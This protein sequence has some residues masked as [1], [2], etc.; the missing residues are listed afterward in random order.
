ME[1]QLYQNVH[2]YLQD[3]II[4][5]QINDQRNLKKWKN[6]CKPYHLVNQ[7]LYRKTKWSPLT[8]VIKRGETASLIFLYHNDPLAGHLGTTKVMQKMKLQYF[9]PQMYEEI[10]EYIQS[11]HQCQ[12]HART[13]KQN[14]LYP[15][16]ISAPWERVGIDF[17]GPFPE[18][19]KGNKYI[20]TAMDYFTRWPEARAVPTATSQEAA[21]FIY[22]ELICRHGIINI[23]HSDQGTHFVNEVIADLVQR[24]DMKH[25]KITAYHP[26]ANG[27]VERF[28]G[29]LK[30]TLAKLSDE[31]DQWDDLIYPSLFAYRASPID[32]IGVPPA[33]LEYGRALRY[34]L[35]QL[36]G[37][38]LWQRV[39]QLIDKFPLD[40][41]QIRERLLHK[42]NLMKQG[43][44]IQNSYQFKLGEQVLLK[45]E[46]FTPWKKG[47]EPKWEGPFEIAEVLSH[48]TYRLRDYRG[49]QA[50]PINGDRLKSY[51]DRT[52][53]EP[54][55][56]IETEL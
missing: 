48:G 46:T 50:K 22:E 55:V 52:Y 42:Q 23:L 19:T 26:Q 13:G 25:H 29:T 44:A 34:P 12:I 14:E 43:Y 16:P 47:L 11:C 27:L 5:P 56:V 17:V 30:K 9:W 6:F 39:K 41:Q 31:S 32:S 49:I 20:I 1:H 36:P 2:Q 7:V 21:K 3:E 24:F 54:I 10:K 53:L 28:N 40:Q 8:K 4:P 18:T 45:R 38:T 33:F 37:E 35:A 15:I 51:K